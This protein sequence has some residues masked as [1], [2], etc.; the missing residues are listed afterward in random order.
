MTEQTSRPATLDDLKTLLR[1]LNARGVDYL[2]IGGYALA[3][4]GYHRATTDIDLVFPASADTGRRVKEA[5]MLLPDRCHRP[6]R[7]GLKKLPTLQRAPESIAC[8]RRLKIGLPQ[9][10]IDRVPWTRLRS[11]HLLRAEAN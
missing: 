7:L 2:L 1:S 6:S 11:P 5:L 10:E 9:I 8:S 3:A 4:H